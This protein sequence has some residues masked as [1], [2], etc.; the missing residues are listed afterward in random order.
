MFS[1]KNNETRTVFFKEKRMISYFVVGNT[2]KQRMINVE[3]TDN[4]FI[5]FIIAVICIVFI[6]T[7][8]KIHS[9]LNIC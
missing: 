6:L 9:Q 3:E 8:N 5:S 7:K 1:I 4:E 2:I